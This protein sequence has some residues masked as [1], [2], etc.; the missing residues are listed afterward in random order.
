MT[1]NELKH[2]LV[3][4]CQ[5]VT[6]GPMDRP[7]IIVAMAQSAQSAGAA[8]VRIEGVENVRRVAAALTIPVIGIVKRD[9][10]DSPVRITPFIADVED[11]ARAGASIIAFDATDRVRPVPVAELYRAARACQ[12]L[13]MA[14]CACLADGVAAAG[15]GC[16]LIG[17]TLSGYTA[18]TA[19][20]PMARPDL[21]LIAALAARGYN[22]MAEGRIRTQDHAAA[23]LAQG[24]FAVTVGSAVTRVEHITQWFIEALAQ[25]ATRS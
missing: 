6:G 10:I 7:E 23:A 15:L 16:D 25:A 3:V 12:R 1:L 2:R 24:A 22:V 11:L 8:A 20:Q 14:D 4:S 19:D 17:T 21:A 5:P 13:I 9:L 18:G